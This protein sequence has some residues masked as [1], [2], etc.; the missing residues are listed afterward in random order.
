MDKK[1]LIDAAKE[2]AY[3]TNFFVVDKAKFVPPLWPQPKLVSGAGS[4]KKTPSVLRGAGITN[5]LVVT[6]SGSSKKLA[7]PVIEEI[8]KAGMGCAHY[9]K[10]EANPSL[11]TAE[12]IARLYREAGC[13]GFLA[14]GGGSPIDATKAA[15]VRIARPNT[16]LEKIAGV[17]R[18][19]VP[20]PPI[21]AMPT[22]AGTGSE[23]SYAA[24]ITDHH[25]EIKIAIT[26]Q[27]LT[28]KAA[29]LDP[30]LTVGMPPFL[31]ATT[32][33]DALTHAIESYVSAYYRTDFTIRCAEEAVVKIFRNLETAYKDGTNMEARSQ[34]LEASYKAG[35]AFTR[36]GVGN[37]HAIAHALGGKYG[38]AHGLANS[39]ILP[40]V[41][42]D[43]GSA[44][45]TQLAHLAELTGVMSEGTEKQ[46]AAAFI[47]AV[48]ALNQRLGLP[49]GLADI[50]PQDFDH[51]ARTA[52]HEAT[53]TYPTPVIYTVERCKHVLNRILLEA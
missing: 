4:S 7:E 39:V 5:V 15:A 31:T 17:M 6:G 10:V 51:I 29:I 14:I 11:E 36:T 43:Y 25:R 18:V 44:V 47:A 48:R 9:D 21:V 50:K 49:T 52:V 38:I 8:K 2:T 30:V 33:V 27:H 12:Q 46:K 40:I 37:V 19:I 45:Y 24:V 1:K 53:H 42:E 3:R 22:T 32:G 35:L 26:D 20:V 34:M 16:P 13:N 41:L 28:P 23:C